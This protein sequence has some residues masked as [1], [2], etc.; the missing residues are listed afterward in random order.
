MWKGTYI[1]ILLMASLLLQ[2][3]SNKE[4]IKEENSADITIHSKEVKG[5]P[6]ANTSSEAN[7]LPTKTKQETPSK[8]SLTKGEFN[9][10]FKQDTKEKQYP[11]GKFQLKNGS[12]VYADYLMY[13]NNDVFEDATVI[14]YKDELA[15]IQFTSKTTPEEAIEKLG[16]PVTDN[17]IIEQNK[18][19]VC[20]IVINQD[21]HDGNIAVFPNEWDQYRN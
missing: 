19:G 12:I 5:Q 7:T 16:L 11:N 14:F 1:T 4:T 8:I 21:F 9:K 10:M 20:E 2:A 13:G 18:W 15:Q 17:S 6:S 3:C